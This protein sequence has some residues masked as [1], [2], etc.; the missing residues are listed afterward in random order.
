[1]LELRTKSKY[2]T[3]FDAPGHKDYVNNIPCTTQSD[4]ALL[5]VSASLAEFEEGIHETGQTCEHAVIAMAL[6]IKRVV[7]GVNKMDVQEVNYSSERYAEI[8]SVPQFY[9][10]FLGLKYT[11]FILNMT[12][13]KLIVYFA[14]IAH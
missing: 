11:L 6:G 7:V 9:T 3:W 10:A 5:V 8:F 13:N 12:I 14:F 2:Y 1:M 4:A